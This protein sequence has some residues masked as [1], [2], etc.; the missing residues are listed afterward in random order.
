L[1]VAWYL[2]FQLI[3]VVEADSSSGCISTLFF[4]TAGFHSPADTATRYQLITS[5]LITIVFFM[6]L[7]KTN[8]MPSTEFYREK[9]NV[10]LPSHQTA[11]RHA[12]LINS[13]AAR[14]DLYV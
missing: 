3:H 11:N 6:K 12:K 4:A 13:E 10:E 2:Q 1:I 8:S 7:F 5:R 9:F 14:T